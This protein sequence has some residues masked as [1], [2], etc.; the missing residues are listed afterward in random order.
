MLGLALLLLAAEPRPALDPDDAFLAQARVFALGQDFE[1]CLKRLEQ[2]NKKGVSNQR[3]AEID[4]YQ[5]LCQFGL[6]NEKGAMGSWELALRL[7]PKAK[8]PRMQSPKVKELFEKL[9]AQVPAAPEEVAPPKEDLKEVKNDRPE[10]GSCRASTDCSALEL[11]VNNR[12]VP[13]P[14]QVPAAPPPKHLAAP[15]TL[16][17]AGVAAVA[18]GVVFGLLAKKAESDSHAAFFADESGRLA[19]RATTDAL[20]ANICFGV[21][22]AAL[23]TALIVYLVTN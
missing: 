17:V 14:P 5:G 2:A 13:P 21:A 8:L 15:I 3:L 19:T 10:P 7:D 23:V 20:V 6:G 4:L 12:C 18:G 16:G 1:K 22:A 9:R 11:C